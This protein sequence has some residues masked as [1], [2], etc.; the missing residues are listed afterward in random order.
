MTA[1]TNPRRA[2][3]RQ[4]SDRVQQYLDEVSAHLDGVP[5]PDRSDLLDDLGDHLVEVAAESSDPLEVPLG[6]SAAYAEELV[7]SAGLSS[8]FARSPRLERWRRRLAGA[9]PLV[10]L[11]RLR[12]SV[13]RSRSAG[14]VVAFLPELRPGWWVLRGYLFVLALSLL[15]GGDSLF[16]H[17]LGSAVVG[18]ASVGLAVALS[19]RI[20]RG[21]RRTGGRRRATLAADVGLALV[22]LVAVLSMRTSADSAIAD[23][24]PV[25]PVVGQLP[26]NIFPYDAGGRP[27]DGVLLYDQDGRPLELPIEGE[28][29]GAHVQSELPVDADGFPIGN[30]YPRQQRSY[31]WSAG[32]ERLRPLPRPGVVLP[33]GTAVA[34]GEDG[35]AAGS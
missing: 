27:I 9:G 2:T 30:A 5:E 7:A 25:L 21:H 11:D 13:A 33:P 22:G 20:G 29:D 12:S 3:E 34:E 35:E 8:G 4:L 31:V 26:G 23:M 28:R 24:G 18:F 19:V 10:H 16:P 14:E 15:G 1:T 32:E 6:P 17:I